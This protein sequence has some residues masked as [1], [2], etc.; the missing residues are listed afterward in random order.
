MSTFHE[1]K[2]I[3]IAIAINPIFIDRIS[4][5]SNNLVFLCRHDKSVDLRSECIYYNDPNWYP[6]KSMRMELHYKYSDFL[7]ELNNDINCQYLAERQRKSLMYGPFLS[8]IE[9]AKQA[10]FC[11]WLLDSYKLKA[12]INHNF[13]HELFTYILYKACKYFGIKHFIVH[14]SVLP[15]R[16]SIS[17]LNASN[18]SD[19][20]I[21]NSSASNVELNAVIQYKATLMGN[22]DE[23]IPIQDRW[24]LT[25]QSTPLI[26]SEEFAQ[27]RSGNII[28]AIT[29][30]LIKIKIYLSYRKY[31]KPLP[32]KKEFVTYFMHYQPEETTI[33]RGGR[34]AQ[35]LNVLIKLRSIIP[36][37]ISI[38][39]KENKAT[40]RHAVTLA[41]QVRSN[42]F[43]RSIANIPNTYIVS[44]CTD[45]FHLIDS[46]IAIATITG[47]VGLESLARGK[48]AIIFGSAGYSEYKN[49]IRGDLI[50]ETISKEFLLAQQDSVSNELMVDLE[51]ELKLSCGVSEFN[52][53]SVVK[54]QEYSVIEAFRLLLSNINNSTKGL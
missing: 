50:A 3:K 39:V 24:L 16:A 19:K 25:S 18:F 45:T 49:I 17:T 32:E 47:T 2:K 11:V 31:V 42:E 28:Y 4:S 27:F 7:M 40:F 44:D 51:Q 14:H 54:D 21:L 48:R 9:I 46:S 10:S 43:Y 6:F 38:I 29:R 13:P 22:H 23:A 20:K 52:K 33:P 53:I 1:S 26:F 35:Q 34:F 8:S 41:M 37:D 30:I 15:W 12:V 5:I 36:S